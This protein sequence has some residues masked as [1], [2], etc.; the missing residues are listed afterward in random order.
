MMFVSGGAG[1]QKLTPVATGLQP[2]GRLRAPLA[3]IL[4]DVYGTLFISAS[5]DIGQAETDAAQ[6]GAALKQAA[7]P[8]DINALAQAFNL[9]QNGRELHDAMQREIKNTH[10]R[11]KAE[12][13]DCP[14][15]DIERIWETVLGIEDRPTI[16][17]FAWAFEMAVNP[18][19]PMPHVGALLALVAAKNIAAGII[20]NAQFYTDRLFEQFLDNRPDAAWADPELIFYSYR[21][22][23]AKPSLH[24]FKRAKEALAKK[25]IAA[26][27]TLYV[28]NDMLKDIYPARTCGFQTALFAGDARSLRL[29]K[30]DPRCRNLSP[31]L[32]I[33]ELSQL[34][35]LL[36]NNLKQNNHGT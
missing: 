15:V 17:A 8:P 19:W 21:Y 1:T 9:D 23:H 18:V 4:F 24:L 27:N 34:N 30:D 31:D 28:G 10:T 2:G 11:L 33:T 13:R 25:K 36:I 26:Q 3:A 35:T 22:G 32:I 14:E 6:K 20:S 5:G 7:P 16:Q 12:G 29:R